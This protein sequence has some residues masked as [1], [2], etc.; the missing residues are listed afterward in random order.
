MIDPNAVLVVTTESV[1]GYRITAMLGEVFG[2]TSRSNHG[3]VAALGASLKPVHQG[4]LLHFTKTNDEA[5]TEAL[6][7]LREAAAAKGANAVVAMRYALD[8]ISELSITAVAYGTAV[9]LT[10]E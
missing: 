4:E 1:P 9:V 6:T 10:R 2:S 7:R 3:S 8:S 5:H